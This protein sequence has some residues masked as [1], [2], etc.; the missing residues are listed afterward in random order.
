MNRY[1]TVTEFDRSFRVTDAM[2]NELVKEAEKKGIKGNEIEKGV[3]RRET[4]ILLKAYIARDLFD[5]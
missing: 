5:D 1:K 3:A 4:D 2:F